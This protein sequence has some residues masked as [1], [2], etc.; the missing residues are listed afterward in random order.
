EAPRVRQDPLV[1]SLIATLAS[2]VL[3][4]PVGEQILT[5]GNLVNFFTQIRRW[6]GHNSDLIGQAE[7]PDATQYDLQQSK[8]THYEAFNIYIPYG[9]ARVDLPSGANVLPPNFAN[10]FSGEGT[11]GELASLLGPVGA[12]SEGYI[13]QGEPLPYTIQFENASTAASAVGEVRI[14]TQLDGDLDPRSFRLGDLRLGDLQ[15]NIPDGRSFFQGDFD[16]RTSKG[17]ILRVSAGLDPLSNTATWLICAIDPLT[18]EVIQ[19]PSIGLL[20][21]NDVTGAGRGFV[22]YT[23]QIKHEVPTGT[24][25]TSTARIL[26]NTSAPF[27]TATITNLVDAVAPTTSVTVTPLVLGESNYL[28]KWTATDDEMGS[29]VKHVTVYVSENGGNFTIWKRQTTDT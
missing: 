13:P 6:Y 23:V 14:V 16:F 9:K 5:N 24:E 29:G 17:F 28:V 27:D 2:G 8:Q 1:V 22:T 26:Y 3:V 11:V 25:I 7:V 4:G 19:D 18:G 15:I 20:P 12:L 10:F 21:P